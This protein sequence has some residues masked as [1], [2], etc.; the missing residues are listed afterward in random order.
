MKILQL[1]QKPQR[2]GAEVF[3]Y[4]LSQELR[5]Q[6]HCVHT[7]YLYPYHGAGALPFAQ[8]TQCLNGIEQH[9]LERVL[10]VHPQLLQSLLKV[11]D[12]TQPDIIQVNGSRTVKY[13][14]LAHRLRR[15]QHWA[16]VYRN[17]GNP[18]DWMRSLQHRLF[19]KHI[20][21]P[22]LDGIIGVSRTTLENVQKIYQL[23]IP[24]QNIPRGVDP[25][26]LQPQHNRSELRASLRIEE[27]RPVVLYVGSLTPE[28][29]LDR[30]LSVFQQVRMTL[31]DAQLWI[32]GD[33]PLRDTLKRLS[34]NTG[35]D[36]AV[37]F[38]G[39]QSDV[40]SYMGAADLLALTSDTEGIPG[41]ILEAGLLGLPAVA[42]NVGGVAECVIDGKTGILVDPKY[43]ARLTMA[44]LGL[45]QNSSQR[46][47]MGKLAQAWV[48]E[49][50]TI[51]RIAQQYLTFYTQVLA[52]IHPS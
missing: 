25:K 23:P 42:T 9:T 46:K 13:G 51:E 29:R 45:L 3:A 52:E 7:I 16:L 43:E 28:K 32:V 49:K 20:I 47:E 37:H 22:E 17:I 18:Q 12:K 5:S 41:V 26:A 48:A 6:A 27:S 50:F 24:T 39:V 35:L 38:M 8:D 30:L 34:M 36:A 4:H 33:G 2:R 19:Y 10:G 11:I 14:A 21:M 44:L 1:V 40:A 31:T 15:G